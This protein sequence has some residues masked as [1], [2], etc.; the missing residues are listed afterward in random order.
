MKGGDYSYVPVFVPQKEYDG[1]YNGHA[2]SLL[3][4]LFHYFPCYAEYDADC[5]DR[6]LLVNCLFAATLARRLR[7][8]GYGLDP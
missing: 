4:P 7:P 8:G 6:Y 2:N 3:W 5:Y 1:Y